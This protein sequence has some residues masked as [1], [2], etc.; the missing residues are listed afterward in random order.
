M[1]GVHDFLRCATLIL[2]Y[3]ITLNYISSFTKTRQGNSDLELNITI[4]NT[5]YQRDFHRNGQISAAIID[6]GQFS[7]KQ[8]RRKFFKRRMVYYN[9]THASYIIT[10]AGYYS[11][12]A[13]Q[14]QDQDKIKTALII[15]S[16][17]YVKEQSASRG[18]L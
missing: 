3:L 12:E 9:N 11:L 13:A 6:R 18:D 8:F 16:A 1:A 7:T 5:I 4:K 10:T 2:I 14:I 15:R 17:F